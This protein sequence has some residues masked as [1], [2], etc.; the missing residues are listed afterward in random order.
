MRYL[1]IS[2]TIYEVIGEDDSAYVVTG[3]RKGTP[4]RKSKNQV[5]EDARVSEN[6]EELFDAYVIEYKDGKRFYFQKGVLGDDII[7][8]FKPDCVD[9]FTGRKKLYGCIWTGKYP[10]VKPVAMCVNQKWEIIRQ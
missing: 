5:G 8:L 3:K 7:D 6:V 1:R 9:A 10:T 4:Y 2:T